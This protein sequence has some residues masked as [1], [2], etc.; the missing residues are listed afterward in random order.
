ML[1]LRRGPLAVIGLGGAVNEDLHCRECRSTTIYRDNT[2][3]GDQLMD[4]KAI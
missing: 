2:T 4:Q 1:E 3:K